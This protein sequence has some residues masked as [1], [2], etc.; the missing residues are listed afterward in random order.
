MDGFVLVRATPGPECE[1]HGLF[2]E[3]SA[4]LVYVQ[5]WFELDHVLCAADTAVVL[6]VRA[7]W[8]TTLRSAAR[9]LQ[10][11]TVLY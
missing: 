10:L 8:C 4:S 11:L 5:C 9:T 2:E 7:C 3:G 1:E 6:S